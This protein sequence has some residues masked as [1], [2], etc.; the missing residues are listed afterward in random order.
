MDKLPFCLY[1]PYR[2]STSVTKGFY[3]TVK[4]KSIAKN[5]TSPFNPT[6]CLIEGCKILSPIT[7]PQS[8]FILQYSKIPNPPRDNTLPSFFF[9]KKRTLVVLV[10]T[11]PQ[12]D[13]K[14][15]VECNG[16]T[17]D[18]PIIS[19]LT[20]RICLITSATSQSYPHVNHPSSPGNFALGYIS[21]S[22]P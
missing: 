5:Y 15:T 6:H 18:D 4:V 20:S 12:S 7:N 17:I 9:F 1:T 2:I 10:D 11:K 3:I 16:N 13:Y 21:F 8:R 19:M 22:E 14:L